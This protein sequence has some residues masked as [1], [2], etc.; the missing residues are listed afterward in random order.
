MLCIIQSQAFYSS[1][2]E[3][4]IR[5]FTKKSGATTKK[6]LTNLILLIMSLI[7]KL[8]DWK[9]FELYLTWASSNPKIQFNLLNKSNSTLFL[10]FM[11]TKIYFWIELLT[12][13]T[14]CWNW[15]DWPGEAS[16]AAADGD[17]GRHSSRRPFTAQDLSACECIGHTIIPQLGNSCSGRLTNFFGKKTFK[18]KHLTI[19]FLI[20]TVLMVLIVEISYACK[21]R[22][23]LTQLQFF[24]K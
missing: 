3:V 7:R 24:Y 19:S 9:K 10:I 20:F 16:V 17:C 23:L 1:I 11:L 14:G 22:N 21:C 2:F 12:C 5:K 8:L 13:G 15:E 6:V 18:K 4:I